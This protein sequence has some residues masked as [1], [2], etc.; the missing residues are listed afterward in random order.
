MTR[1][2][3][4]F[5]KV[6][7]YW[8]YSALFGLSLLLHYLTPYY[9][10]QNQDRWTSFLLIV[11]GALVGYVIHLWNNFVSWLLYLQSNPL[12]TDVIS[13]TGV[14]CCLFLLEKFINPFIDKKSEI[15]LANMT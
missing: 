12:L 13:L 8:I 7:K 5:E 11:Y 15:K 2:N 3:T 4:F 1:G 9:Q 6:D 10:E 14:F